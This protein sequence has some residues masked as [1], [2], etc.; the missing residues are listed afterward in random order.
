MMRTFSARLLPLGRSFVGLPGRAFSE[1]GF[2]LIEVLISAMLVGLI[3]VGVFTGLAGANHATVNERRNSQATV[4]A[5][6][7]E[8]RLRGLTVAELTNLGSTPEPVTVAE[9]GMCVE[10]T[11]GAWKYYSGATTPFCE[12]V[13]GFKGTSYTGA[14][15]TVESSAQFVTASKET[16]TCETEKGTADYIETSSSVTWPSIGKHAAISQSSLVAVPR[17][18]TLLVKITNRNN[19]PVPDAT[20]AV[21]DPSPP[22][23]VTAEQTTP[24]SGCVIF[25]DLPEGNAKVLASKGTWI[26]K[27]RKTPAEQSTTITTTK[28]AEVPL[29]LEEPG[30]I[31]AEFINNSGLHVE[32]STFVTFQNEMGSPPILVG[33]EANKS[34]TSAVLGGLFPF[35]TPGHPFTSNKYTVYAGDC[36]ANNPATVGVSGTTTKSVQ[37]EPGTPTSESVEVAPINV[38][39]DE[40][41]K[42]LSEKTLASS[43]S[44]KII[45]TACNGAKNNNGESVKYE[46]E[47]KIV[48]G[49]LVPEYQP[50]ATSLELCVVGKNEKTS[51]YF[52]TKTIFANTLKTGTAATS[53]YLAEGATATSTTKC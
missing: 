46:H 8:E 25:G 3:G 51:K 16:L 42:A 35:V 37:V 24:S 31:K 23:T 50:Y 2:M 41:T 45:N 19:E 22:S 20:V 13:T 34:S 40:G 53:I 49:K 4:I 26:T 48:G 12:A 29:T 14:V 44:A 52:K 30:G 5:Q 1:D 28:L 9:N 27:N 15:F 10:G 7:D 6:Q 18:G 11:T 32:S 38:T 47:V 33:G 43:T 21:A 36:E 39:V 17:S